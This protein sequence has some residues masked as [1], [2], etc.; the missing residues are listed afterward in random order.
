MSKKPSKK[1]RREEQKRKTRKATPT[2]LL[3]LPLVVN[4]GQARRIRGHLEAGRQLYNALLSEGQKRLRRMRAD[5]GW[6]AARA[7]PRNQP[8]ERR[9][10]L[11]SPRGADRVTEYELHHAGPTVRGGFFPPHNEALPVST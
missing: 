7:I 1:H 4:A 5:P 2:F 11:F 8:I 3:E 9:A 10:G 6:K